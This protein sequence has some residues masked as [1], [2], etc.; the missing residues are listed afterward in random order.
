MIK[1]TG[2][3]ILSFFLTRVLFVGNSF[4]TIINLSKNSILISSFIGMILGIIILFLFY[5]KNTINKY[6]NIILSTTILIIISISNISLTSSYLLNQTPIFIILIP[7]IL[8]NI[9]G[10]SKNMV[11]TS[12]ISTIIIIPTIIII[13]FSLCGLT[14][15]VNLNNLFPLFNTNLKNFIIAILS[16][17]ILSTLPNILL[18]NYKKKLSFKEISLGYI[19]GSIFIILLM[20][21]II[22]IY[23]YELSSLYKYPEYLILKKIFI[24][25]NIN[26]IENILLL[27]M[28]SCIII[29][30]LVCTNILRDNLH[31]KTFYLLI[32][33]ITTTIL[34]ILHKLFYITIIIQ[35]YIIYLYFILL[36]I[37]LIIPSKKE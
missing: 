13:I 5:K 22:S 15:L 30:S 4:N 24:I 1:K 37:S 28:I 35:N 9:F 26:N 18:L 17:T 7:F 6:I 27:E 31:Q 21:Y 29:T 36:I 32:F 11:T 25:N 10:S 3:I 12:R 34:I 33:I 16:F 19:I 8:L 23:G 20:F 2:Y 14:S